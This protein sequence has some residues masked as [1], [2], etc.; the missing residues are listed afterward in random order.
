MVTG[1]PISTSFLWV[2]DW[3]TDPRVLGRYKN[4]LMRMIM[5]KKYNQLRNPLELIIS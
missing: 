1:Y 3:S 4:N 2:D 5:M